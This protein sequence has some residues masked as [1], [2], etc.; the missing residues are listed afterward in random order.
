MSW[1]YAFLV[2]S[3]FL[4][5]VFLL[6]DSNNPLAYFKAYRRRRGGRWA[7][8]SSLIPWA[9]F[10]WMRVD[11]DCAERTDEDYRSPT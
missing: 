8:C 6:A 5:A 4:G 9:P 10:M 7:Q 11:D 1:L 3:A 2:C